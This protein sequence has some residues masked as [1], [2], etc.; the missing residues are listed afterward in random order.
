ME[1][2]VVAVGIDVSK[3]KLDVAVLFSNGKYRTKVVSNDS[4]GFE[5]LRL[6]LGKQGVDEGV[7]VCMEARGI[8]WEGVAGYL[9]DR[10][11][12]VSVVN[13]FQVKAFGGSRLARAKTDRV[14][15]KLIAEFC[16]K[17]RPEPWSA[18]SVEVREVGAR[19]R[20]LHSPNLM[21]S[22][23]RCPMR[24]SLFSHLFMT[25]ICLSVSG[26]RY[27]SFSTFNMLMR[28]WRGALS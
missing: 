1:R 9:F 16:A 23:M 18:P 4:K 19:S 14:D 13:P 27:P 7:H 21:R 5:E 3:R 12:V 11:F 25:S 17:E 28:A 2:D 26:P 6:W 22:S 24:R 10:G 15:A 20:A 8:Y